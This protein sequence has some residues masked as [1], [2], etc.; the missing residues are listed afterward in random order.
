MEFVAIILMYTLL[1]TL[2]F[3]LV[4]KAQSQKIKQSKKNTKRL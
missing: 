4:P 2:T 3:V 1:Y